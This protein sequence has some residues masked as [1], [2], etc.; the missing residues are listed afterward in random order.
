MTDRLALLKSIV[1]EGLK[2]RHMNYKTK[3]NIEKVISGLITI[4]GF[5][6]I[7][8]GIGLFIVTAMDAWGGDKSIVKLCISTLLG[9]LLIAISYFVNI[10]THETGHMIF[11]LLSGYKFNSIRF[12]KLMLVR[13]GGQDIGK[14]KF[15]K[16]DLPGTAG[17][18]I[19][20]APDGDAEHMP[21]FLYNVGGVA[22]NFLT[23]IISVILYVVCKSSSSVAV[24]IVGAIILIFGM[25]SLVIGITNSLPFEQMGTDGANIRILM[26]DKNSRKAFRNSLEIVKY[27]S[28]GYSLVEMPQD[29]TYFDKNTPMNNTLISAQ[30]SMYYSY[31]IAKKEYKEAKD[32]ALFILDNAKSINQIHVKVLYGDLVFLYAVIE[33]NLEA[34]RKM[35]KDHEKDINAGAGFISIQKA[36]YAY[37][38]LVEVDKKKA[39]AYAKAFENSYKNYPYPKDAQVEKEQFDMVMQVASSKADI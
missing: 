4:V 1:Q 17:Q 10:C 30:A 14:L 12:G 29:L 25:V 5:G 26:R 9:L 27:F 34:S 23:A 2:G 6:A 22:V 38:T 8:A 31:L 3:A 32:M 16:Y 19:M 7:G 13:E 24:I 28:E 36:L 20:T 21:V 15:C 37:Y 11:G 33:N 39:D 35:Y 18:C